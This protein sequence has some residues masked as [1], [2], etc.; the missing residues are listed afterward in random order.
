MSMKTT[1]LAPQE[2]GWLAGIFDGEGSVGIS[3]NRPQ[4]NKT[5]VAVPSVQMSLSCKKTID[6]IVKML[7]LAGITAIGYS[8]QRRDPTKHLDAHY[9]RIGR[10]SDTLLISKLLGP[11]SFTKH[12]QWRLVEEFTGLRL[13]GVEIRP[14]GTVRRG[15]TA[16]RKYSK[17]E[18]E[19]IHELRRLNARGARRITGNDPEWEKRISDLYKHSEVQFG[20][21]RKKHQP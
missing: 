4:R 19:I 2:I 11:H 14:D 9:I 12:E 21:E 18:V 15:G 8:Y 16:P 17:R 5:I 20:R 3:L 10:L 7:K 6:K 13:S 1:K